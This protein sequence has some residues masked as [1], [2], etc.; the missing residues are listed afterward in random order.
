MAT[1]LPAAIKE[2][3]LAMAE[4]RPGVHRVVVELKD[5]SVFDNV[6]VAW[7]DEVVR[8][9]GYQDIPFDATEVSAVFESAR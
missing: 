6:D 5:G 2:R 7:G 9:L 8:V 1:V 3:I 4:F